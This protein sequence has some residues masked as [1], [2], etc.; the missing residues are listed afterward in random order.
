MLFR[1][2]M[3][4]K[5]IIGASITEVGRAS[6]GTI[7]DVNGAFSLKIG[8]NSILKVRSLG[9]NEKV[10]RVDGK[11]QLKI[12]LEEDIKRLDDIVVI[13]Y[14]VQRKSDLT[15]AVGTVKFEDVLKAPV[16]T[17]DQSLA[18]RIAGVQVSSNDGQPGSSANIVIR[19]GNSLTQ[20]NAPL[21][22]IDGFPVE[23]IDDITLNPNEIESMTVLKD[24]S[25]TAI[26]GA[27]GSN[28]VIVIETKQHKGSEKLFVNFDSA[29]IGRASCGKEC[30]SRWSPY[31]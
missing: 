14:G 1:S 17:V 6:N 3:M 15:G 23:S 11:N 18:G 5:P 29:E 30:R 19:G 26:Y 13:G 7:S 10:V 31:H 12:E 4:G 22:V 28:G 21:Y 25:S 9:Y 16:A 2:G 20:S 27:R 24:A 8:S